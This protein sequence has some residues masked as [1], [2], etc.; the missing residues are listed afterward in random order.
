MN[1]IEG[2]DIIITTKL[3]NK[4]ILY[5]IRFH[6]TSNCSCLLTNDSKNVLIKTKKGQSWIFRSKTSLTLE[7]S[8]Y[9][10]DGKKVEQTKQIVIS[11]YSD[12]S[13]QK[14]FWSITKT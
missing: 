9:I 6:L 5:N 8:I 2:E 4:K 11:N 12:A 14:Q 13:K 10:K 1:K 3:Y 7:D